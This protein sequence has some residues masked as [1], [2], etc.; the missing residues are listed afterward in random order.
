MFW[1]STLLARSSLDS[2][3]GNRLRTAASTW[4]VSRTSVVLTSDPLHPSPLFPSRRASSSPTV[5]TLAL[6]D[7]A[8]RHRERLACP[9]LA[10]PSPFRAETRRVGELSST[11]YRSSA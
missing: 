10:I 3:A 4:A 5:A 6:T 9:C 7:L 11:G 1:D 2:A 8:A